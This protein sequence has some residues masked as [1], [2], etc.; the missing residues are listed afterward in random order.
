MQGLNDVLDFDPAPVLLK[1]LGDE[2]SVAV[3][4]LVLATQEAALFEKVFGDG[5]FD[6]AL[7]H[8]PEKIPF[9]G[10]PIAFLLLV[11]VQK[12]LSGRKVRHMDVVDAGDSVQEIF[13][14][15]LFGEARQL[16]N[17]VQTDVR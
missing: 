14:V 1:V 9:V 3:V 7:S 2:A 15:V 10:G 5:G 8:E 17:V 13:Q 16:R 11:G 4:G 6:A 12:F